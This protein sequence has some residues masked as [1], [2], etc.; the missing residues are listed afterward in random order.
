MLESEDRRRGCIV[1]TF[2]LLFL[3]LTA[4]VTA[5]SVDVV[6]VSGQGVRSFD[7]IR[8][9]VCVSA[10]VTQACEWVVVVIRL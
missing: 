3:P 8:L 1:A 9:C 10:R 7:A 2:F 5:N 4:A 6:T